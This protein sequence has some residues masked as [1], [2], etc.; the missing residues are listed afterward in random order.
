MTAPE[1]SISIIRYEP[2]PI[3]F[4]QL[5]EQISAELPAIEYLGLFEEAAGLEGAPVSFS[6][7]LS[8]EY[9]A[10]SWDR[11]GTVL[12]TG[13]DVEPTNAPIYVDGFDKALEYGG[14]P[15]VILALRHEQLDRTFREV[16]A[17]TPS[18]QLAELERVFGTKL[19]SADGSKLWLSRLGA[20]DPSL[21]TDYE[22]AYAR[23]V[24]GDALAA[25]A[26]VFVLVHP[27]RGGAA[28]IQS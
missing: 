19:P 9:R 21:T 10:T 12:C 5:A 11:L 26:A 13:I 20:D 6:D 24:P 4:V 23:W 16:S 7:L 22:V 15:K 25:L 8:C 27:L 3:F 28:V 14:W 2:R 17:D 18:A 1:Y